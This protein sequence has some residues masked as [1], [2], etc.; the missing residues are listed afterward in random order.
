M[1]SYWLTWLAIINHLVSYAK[2][3]IGDQSEDRFFFLSI[4]PGT[5]VSIIRAHS[6]I[7]SQ[8]VFAYKEDIFVWATTIV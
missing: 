3:R 7:S 5:M 2:F 6:P 1:K 8:N 4:D